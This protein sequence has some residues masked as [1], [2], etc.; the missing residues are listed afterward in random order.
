M[1]W[2]EDRLGFS[3]HTSSSDVRAQSAPLPTHSEVRAEPLSLRL[4][5]LLETLAVNRNE[6][7]S[8]LALTRCTLW[9]AVLRFEHLQRS[10]LVDLLGQGFEGTASLGKSRI[11]GRRRPFSWLSPR[12]GITGLDVGL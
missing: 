4:L 8:S 6:F 7:V 9:M 1:K 5:L 2:L 3:F 10:Q 11:R 12:N